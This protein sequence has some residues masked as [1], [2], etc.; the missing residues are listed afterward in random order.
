MS[1][2]PAR[3]LLLH[4]GKVI[5]LDRGSRVAEAVAVRDGR[6]VVVGASAPLLKDASPATRSIALRGRSVLPGCLDA[7]PHVD[8]EGLRA[9]GGISLVGLTSVA[10][11]VEEVRR[12][13]SRARPGDWIVTMPMGAP[14]HDFISRP[15]QL[16]E[17]RFPTR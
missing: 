8:R 15:D 4:G 6:I 1:P 5:T 12:A 7:H 2:G 17:G 14:P 11:I 16:R 3:D 10:E 9:R 13:A